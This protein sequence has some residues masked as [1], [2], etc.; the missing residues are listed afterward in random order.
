M[1]K[2]KPIASGLALA[3]GGLASALLI[4]TPAAAQQ[5]TADS[6][7]LERVEI[8]GSLIPRIQGETSLPVTV[9]SA[10]DLRAVG[11][12][13]AQEALTYVTQNQSSTVS[14][15]S[16]GATNGGAS[17]ADLRGLGVARTLVLLNGQ[18]VVNNPY[19]GLAVDLNTIPF[20]SIDRIEVLAE[21]ASSIYG[22]DAIAGVI[23]FITRKEYQGFNISGDA[24]IPQQNGGTRYS[25]SIGGGYGALA[26][27]GWN[28]YGSLSY[29]KQ[30]VLQSVDRS[31]A[32]SGIKLD[33]GYAR[34]SGTTFPGNYS[35]SSTRVATNPTLPNCAPS[36]SV[37]V[38]ALFGPNSCRFDFTQ[39]VDLVPE[40]EQTNLFAKGSLALGAENTLSLEYF[41]S[42]NTLSAAV[43]PTPLT[44]L[45][46]TSASP[47]YPGGSAGV[48]IT[49]PALDSSLPIS[50]GWR[51]IDAG[52][53]ASEIENTTQRILG[54]LDGTVVGWNYALNA[55][56]SSS[57]V[58]NTFTGGYVNRTRVIDGLAGRNGAPFLN[59]FGAQ[60]AAGA[61]YLNSV[62]VL[63]QVQDISGDLWGTNLTVNKE[64][65]DLP[66]GPLGLALGVDY[67]RQSIDFT[68]NFA[69]IR[70][71]ASSGLELAEDTSGNQSVSAFVAELSIP[72]IKN[73]DVNM[74]VRYDKYS[75]FSGVWS[76][77]VAARWQ[78]LDTVLLRGSYNQGFRAPTVFD[79][80][81]P[82]S[83]TFTSNA[84]DDPVLCPNGVA[85]P[86][87]DPA[88]DCQQQ[89]QQQQGGNKKTDPEESD[90]WSVGFVLQPIKEVSFSLDYWN[91]KVTG[92]IDALPETAVFGNPTF[93]ASSFVR[94]SQLTPAERLALQAT[95]GGQST[96]DP[97]AYIIGT[98]Q[99]LGDLKAAG[100][101]FNLQ[102]KSPAFEWGKLTVTFAGTYLTQWEQQLV[103]NGE[104]YS[105]LGRYSQELNFPAFRFQSVLSANWQFGPW[106]TIVNNR[107]RSSYY[108]QND[109]SSLLPGYDQNTVGAQSVWDLV[110]S[111]AGFKGVTLTA[112]VQN[113]FNQDPPFSNQGATFQSGYDPRY[114]SP[115][116]RT[117]LLRAAYEFK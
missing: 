111:Y 89:F 33:R 76:P 90:S 116:G 100:L 39:Y 72:V 60:T 47:Y 70:Q 96:V 7:K 22:A 71:A 105:A 21:G 84:Y 13:N 86:G 28:V 92:L 62:K 36:Q 108:D 81:A 99:N 43:A 35:Q 12:T 46:L 45:P 75:D 91:T 59:P 97:L 19:D 56:Y 61:A 67:R 66:A 16:V 3:F 104:Y 102:Y 30:D 98:T 37:L 31:Y 74:A 107:Y 2:T 69:L 80:F 85:V 5:Q 42:R 32:A 110:F 79:L 103:E 8:T 20:N 41:W 17:Y 65:V 77:K 49:N 57:Q 106:T 34:S 94:C 88:R 114:S 29:I 87:A 54:T 40:Q 48:P 1:F 18:R 93:Y 64:I 115:L 38:P 23:N 27:E 55:Y 117:W 112:G 26:K 95:C 101:D 63:G 68:N 83:L 10:N 50:V 11:V 25:A 52:Q 73:L 51:T 24:Q 82:N 15:S 53:R 44:S 113:L 109:A 14:A 78:A 6:Q 4:A 58:D 9:V